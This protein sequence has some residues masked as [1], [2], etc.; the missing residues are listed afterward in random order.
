MR[1]LRAAFALHLACLGLLLAAQPPAPWL[2]ALAAAFGASW[3]WT[4]RHPALGFGPR[5]WTRWIW[6]A[7]GG[8][9]LQR[10]DGPARD[11]ELRD[12]AIVHG[13]WLVLRVRLQ[14]GATAT[15]VL[16]GDELPAETMRRLRA[17]LSDLPPNRQGPGRGGPHPG[18][19]RT[20]KR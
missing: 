16:L 11:G 19:D 9:T 5:A 2:V 6:H 3:L 20:Q 17:R 18:T 8:W 13:P 12:D 4:R 1:A 14:D 15:R 10:G 7:D